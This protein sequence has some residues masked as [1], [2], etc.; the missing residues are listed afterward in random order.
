MTN[1]PRLILSAS[2]LALASCAPSMSTGGPGVEPA[3]SYDVTDNSTPYTRCLEGLRD[4]QVKN[5]PIFSVGEVTDKTGQVDTDNG[6]HALT[7]GASEM[8]ISALAKT[9]K[10]HL[11]ER[12]DLRIPLAEVKLAE[13]KRLTRSIED[14]G[15][16]PASDFI[17]T[18]AITELN[19]NIVSGGSQLYVS[20]I[21]GGMRMVVVNV[22]MDLR[23]VDSKTFAVRYVSALQKQ[24][25]GY[26]VEANVFRFF[27]DTLVELGAGMIRN[28]PLQLGV[29]SVVEMSVYDIMTKFLKLPEVAGCRLTEGAFKNGA[30]DKKQSESVK[31]LEKGVVQHETIND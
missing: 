9:G 28:E 27:G 2:V 7:Q 12:L 21:G 20:G 6:G 25:L 26:E 29:R 8:V 5:L 16:I 14:Y 18:G 3:Y 11:V 15:K 30:P 23:V 19:Y 17:V 13:Q 31:P 10:A 24:I 1:L 22:A 4:I